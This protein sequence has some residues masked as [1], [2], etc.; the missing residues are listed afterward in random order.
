MGELYTGCAKGSKRMKIV[1]IKSLNINS[2]KGLFEIDFEAYLKGES[3]FA[4]TGPTGS[5]KSTILDIISCA[6]YAR[7][8]RLQNPNELMTRHTGKCLCEVEFEIKGKRYRSSW[9]QKR[10]REKADGNFQTAKMEIVDVS[11]GKIVESKLREVPKYVEKLSGLDFERF[12][13]SMML[14]QGSFDAFLKAKESERSTLLEKMTGTHIYKQISQEVY[15][16]YVQKKRD[17]EDELLSLGNIALLEAEVVDT[18]NRLLEAT[19]VEK[20]GLSN[21]AESLKKISTWLENVQKLEV[22]AF[23][24]SQDFIGISKEKEEKKEQFVK[25][26]LANNALQIQ[27]LYKEKS[28]LATTLVED[29]E[30]LETLQMELS[31]IKKENKIKTEEFNATKERFEKEKIS[32]AQESV[33]LK[34]VRTLQTKIELNQNAS[35]QIEN[36]LTNQY[37]ALAKRFHIEFNLLLHDESLLTIQLQAFTE[38][39]ASLK[40]EFET[41]VEAFNR[42]EEQT[43]KLAKKESYTRAR[44]TKLEALLQGLNEYEKLIATIETEV[45]EQ[46]QY[47]TQIESQ[48]KINEEKLKLIAQIKAT[49]QALKETREKELLIK[50]YEADRAKLKQGEACFL[51]G[52]T[53]H[54]YSIKEIGV[55]I[56]STIQKMSEQQERLESA[57]KEQREIELVIVRLNAKLES[58][59]LEVQKLQLNKASI[60]ALFSKTDFTLHTHSKVDINEEKIACEQE[61]EALSTIRDQR[62]RL[63]SQKETLQSR[64]NQK[65]QDELTVKN[66]I[67]TIEGLNIEAKALEREI[68][69]DRAKSKQLLDIEDVNQFETDITNSIHTITDRYNV[70]QNELVSLKSKDELL[71]TQIVAL[72]VKQSNDTTTLEVLQREFEKALQAYDFISEIAFENALLGKEEFENISMVC[73]NIEERYVQIETLK[74]ETSNRLEEQKKRNLSDR[75]IEDVNRELNSLQISIDALQK[76]IGSLEKELEI[77]ASN[78]K[79]YEEKIKKIEKKKE[80]FKVWVKLNEMIGSATGDKFAKFAQGIT[81][82]QLIFLANQHLEVLSPRY[83]LQ[84]GFDS[85]KLLEIEIIDGFQGG[86]VRGVNTLSGGESFIVSLS[87]ALGLS[88]LASQKISIDSLFLDEGFGTLDA[89]SLELALHAL[90]RLQSA[91]KMVGVISH[92]EA[93]KE[94]IPL[95]IKVVPKGDGSSF[96]TF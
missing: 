46:K 18:K 69:G 62:D 70:L 54:P 41:V 24:Y 35:T 37:Q 45:Q 14:A 60:E 23:R 71:H 84:R 96:L 20:Q 53:E 25:L 44:V 8:A 47:Q 82:D 42:A 15:D 64:L 6:L 5:G 65:L 76:S 17:I 29:R 48:T 85:S 73:K 87:L 74:V 22:D 55:D 38:E 31:H 79:K 80:A 49:L 94:R 11:T 61:L 75:E 9:S 39:I 34:S 95:Q 88:A 52:S 91:G 92:V 50:N 10:A 67:G 32:Y 51:C 36:R 30:K 16:I 43:N 81:L 56:S 7:T 13:Q 77:N 57:I 68:E 4:I 58:S 33:K 89:D 93:L 21:K 63:N 27:P 66:I 19:K 26:N 3:L 90:N 2:L 83:V 86:V 40:K 12:T 59:L 1:K 28:M 78:F 72:Q